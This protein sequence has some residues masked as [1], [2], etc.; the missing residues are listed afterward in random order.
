MILQGAKYDL[1]TSG[2]KSSH[3]LTVESPVHFSGFKD[4]EFIVWSGR[5]P[6]AGS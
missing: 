2:E 3:F 1:T 4:K 5:D 6:E